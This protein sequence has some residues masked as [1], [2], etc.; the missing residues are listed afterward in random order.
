MRVSFYNK[1]KILQKFTFFIAL[2]II[3]Q[4]ALV[5]YLTAPYFSFGILL[6]FSPIQNPLL[7]L[8]NLILT[9]LLTYVA[10]I[11]KGGF[12]YYF[13]NSIKQ[14]GCLNYPKDT[15]IR[16]LYIRSLLSPIAILFIAISGSL[17]GFIYRSIL[18]A[19]VWNLYSIFLILIFFSSF[20]YISRVVNSLLEY[21]RE[22]DKLY[23]SSI[24]YADKDLIIKNQVLIQ[25][26]KKGFKICHFDKITSF[27]YVSN[28]AIYVKCGALPLLIE[29]ND[30]KTAFKTLQKQL[31]KKVTSIPQ[32]TIDE[33]E[34]YMNAQK[35]MS[36]L[37]IGLFIASIIFLVILVALGVITIYIPFSLLSYY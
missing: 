4:Y 13:L 24:V 23:S 20:G 3:A 15:F 37:Y 35:F 7:I 2:V 22:I 18:L 1:E 31:E 30:A 32:V 27:G 17:I 33:I 12:S 10:L 5:A 14:S 26:G 25:R 8:I 29:C 28:K 21:S 34:S 6:M 9:I 16:T 11:F 19:T 36:H